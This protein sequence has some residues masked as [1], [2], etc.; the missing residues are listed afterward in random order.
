ME[1]K[2]IILDTD[3]GC[4]CDDTGA[5]AVLHAL[6]DA[7]EAEI[8]AITHVTSTKN[9][10]ACIDIINRYYGRDNIMIGVLPETDFFSEDTYD[11]YA[12]KVANKFI[13]SITDRRHL[14]SA[15]S[16]IRKTL[17]KQQDNSVTI[18]SIGQLRNMRYLLQSEP[19]CHSPLNGVDLIRQKVAMLVVMGG[20]FPSK[21]TPGFEPIEV[22]AEYNIACDIT[23]AKDVSEKWPS[24]I[25]YSGFEIGYRINT[26]IPLLEAADESNP[27]R[28]AYE[29]YSGTSRHSWDQTAVLFA[30]RGLMDYWD[31]S[32][33]GHIEVTDEGITRFKP[34]NDKK[35]SYLI[36]KKHPD[37]MRQIIDKLML[38]KSFCLL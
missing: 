35:H 21:A 33:F 23:S 36:E 8:L 3:I 16:V 37:E 30:V 27:V 6:A 13:S 31:L 7:N 32:S 4:D 5:L 34:S 14:P 10:P 20:C 38:Q 1:T 24:P 29:V 26:G 17:S 15:V 19:D 11:T 22:I 18:V 25:V 9:G 12:T 28:Y 2:K